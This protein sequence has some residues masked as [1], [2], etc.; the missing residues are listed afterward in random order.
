MSILIR[1]AKKQDSSL[2]TNLIRESFNDVAKRFNLTFQNA[3]SHPS[4][5]TKDWV[6]QAINKGITFYILEHEKIACGCVAL[7]QA[8]AEVCYLEKLGVLPGCRNKGFGKALVDHIILEAKKMNMK[9]VEIGIMAQN[10]TLKNWYKKLG[11]I[12]RNMVKFEH[13]P[14][15]VLFMFKII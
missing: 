5:C 10:L 4:N 14:F 1:E 7:E 3:P 8:N 2:L 12:E 9:R 11:F 13:L 15:K 6:I